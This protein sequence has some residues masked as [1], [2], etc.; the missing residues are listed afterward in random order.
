MPGMDCDLTLGGV[1]LMAKVCKYGRG[2]WVEV[3]VGVREEESEGK[4]TSGCG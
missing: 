4:N 2:V 1:C 3:C